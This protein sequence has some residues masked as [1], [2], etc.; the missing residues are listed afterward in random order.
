M[1]IGRPGPTKDN[2]DANDQASKVLRRSNPDQSPDWHIRRLHVVPL[3]LPVSRLPCR[4]AW[5][6]LSDAQRHFV[7]HFA[8]AS[9]SGSR[10]CAHQ[11]S[12]ESPDILKI[13]M[14]ILSSAELPALQTRSYLAGV[15]AKEWMF[16]ISYST[17]FLSNLGNYFGFGD[18]KIV[19][20]IPE[21]KLDR[22]V[23]LSPLQGE[24]KDRL[25]SL[26]E[27][28]RRRMYSLSPRERQLGMPPSGCSA[29]Y[30]EDITQEE[31]ELVA[32]WMRDAH[33]EP[34]NTRIW[35][36]ESTGLYGNL[37]EF[38]L[39]VASSLESPKAS[40]VY[41]N[42]CVIHVIHGDFKKDL[43]EVVGHL[44]EALPYADGDTQRAMLNCFIDYLQTGSVDFH[45]T[46]QVLWLRHENVIDANLGFIETYRDPT[47]S[48][49]EFEAY[50]GV[51]NKVASKQFAA[52]AEKASVLIPSLPWPKDFE[53]EAFHCPA[54]TCI[55]AFVYVNSTIPAAFNLPNYEDVRQIHGSRNLCVSNALDANDCVNK[56]SIVTDEDWE[57]LKNFQQDVFRVQL[58]CHELLGH[59]SGKLFTEDREGTYNFARGK[60][61]HPFFDEMVG[62]CYRPG[63][64]WNSVFGQISSSYEE[65]RADC[66]GIYLS[67][68]PQV[69]EVFGHCGQHAEDIMYLNWLTMARAGFLALNFYSFD[70][71]NWR[72]AHMQGRFAILRTL[73]E[74]SD[75]DA[76]WST[77]QGIIDKKKFLEIV[78]RSENEVVL[79]LNRDKIRT[80][81]VPSISELLIRLQ[82]Y[83][84]TA[85]VKRGRQFFTELTRVPKY[86]LK[87]RRAISADPRPMMVQMNTKLEK[88]DGGLEIS[89]EEF[90]A[91]PEGI[92]KSYLARFENWISGC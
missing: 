65:C 33:L 7:H 14:L 92:I 69:L 17:C 2:F 64:S 45:K 89:L 68:L 42:K 36:S 87:Y 57:L 47:G 84:S 15:T 75:R 24:R 83:R 31:A 81:G 4:G 59:G 54:F 76:E 51:V 66:V 44:K 79:H 78:L 80:V 10:I 40:H 55:E 28:R 58:G 86:M 35:R 13:L 74:A 60:V 77:S 11:I 63:E 56:V 61:R 29:Y 41:K 62:T 72:Q 5:D 53:T 82:V 50:I 12:Q 9:W 26:W 70:T 1:L 8:Q 39:R 30:S 27:K 20:G 18:F 90:D 21:G 19:P 34:W 52:V 23:R 38:D 73:I 67:T 71:G 22:I 85:D 25:L 3:D 49:A 91:T 16:F 32:E 6:S 88:V 46:S 43:Y 37:P 48:R